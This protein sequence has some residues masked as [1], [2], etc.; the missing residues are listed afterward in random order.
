MISAKENKRE[1]SRNRWLLLF[2]D[3]ILLL[4]VWL[5]VFVVSPSA[6]EPFSWLQ[7]LL[8]CA[9]ALGSFFAFRMAFRP[10]TI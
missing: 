7:G 3:S 6:A 2:Y 9:V 10:M 1:R 8:N 4:L 5:A